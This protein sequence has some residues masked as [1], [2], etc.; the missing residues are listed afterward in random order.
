MYQHILEDSTDNLSRTIV[1]IRSTT[2]SPRNGPVQKQSKPHARVKTRQRDLTAWGVCIAGMASWQDTEVLVPI[3]VVPSGNALVPPERPSW[4]PTFPK[5]QDDVPPSVLDL[6]TPPFTGHR[7]FFNLP[8][9]SCAP[10]SKPYFPR[11]CVR[12][13]YGICLVEIGICF[14]HQANLLQSVS[15]CFLF[16]PLPL[17]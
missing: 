6:T 15:T 7:E 13:N 10:W 16:P 8:P 3:G 11:V 1:E 9:F 2:Y 12:S 14:S 5:L 4:H 17:T